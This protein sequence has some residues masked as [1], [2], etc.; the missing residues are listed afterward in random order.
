MNKHPLPPLL[1]LK[2]H[3]RE[4]TY[5]GPFHIRGVA[6]VLFVGKDSREASGGAFQERRVYLRAVY[7]DSEGIV[8]GCIRS[9]YGLCKIPLEN[10]RPVMGLL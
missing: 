2:S 4:L 5:S 8:Y 10:S 7:K 9:I 6:G 3:T 1:K